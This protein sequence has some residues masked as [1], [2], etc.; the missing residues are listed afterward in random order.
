MRLHRLLAI[1][2]ILESRH[3]VKARDLAAALETSERTIY[4]DIEVLAESGIPITAT[5]GPNGGFSLMDG[6]SVNQ[7]QLQGDDV[8]NLYLSGIGVRPESH[9]DASLRLTETLLKL[10]GSLPE[11]YRPDVEKAKQR[12]YFDPAPWW[13]ERPQIAAMDNL[14]RAVW[15]GRKVEFRYRRTSLDREEESCRVVQPYGLVVKSMDWYLVGFCE[16]RQGIRVFRCERID[17]VRLLEE[18]SRIPAGF[19]LPVF[20]QEWT[21]Q[22]KAAVP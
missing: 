11:Q 5:A 20:W 17:Q 6:Y 10:E 12:F 8:V 7:R 19:C 16:L 13:R 21:E 4:R 2:L 3:Q 15:D 14:R 22:F 18:S 1:L 9:S